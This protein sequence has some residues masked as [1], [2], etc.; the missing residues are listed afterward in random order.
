MCPRPLDRVKQ[1]SG[2]PGDEEL[3]SVRVSAGSDLGSART[4]HHFRD[5][6]GAAVA[7]SRH[8]DTLERLIV[9]P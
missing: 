9:I 4:R 3:T 7:S 2:P 8:A 1:G 5:R 6:V